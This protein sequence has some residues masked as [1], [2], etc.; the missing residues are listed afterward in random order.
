MAGLPSLMMESK[1]SL[2]SFTSFAFISS[3]YIGFSRCFMI[4][5]FLRFSMLKSWVKSTYIMGLSL[6][7]LS[8]ALRLRLAQCSKSLYFAK[9][10][11]SLAIFNFFHRTNKLKQLKTRVKTN[12]GDTNFGRAEKHTEMT[13]S[14]IKSSEMTA[15][16][17]KN[18]T[19]NQT[20]TKYV[21]ITLKI[22]IN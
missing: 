6:S 18:K 22:Q 20:F 3:V 19:S 21:L 1:D 12:W 17:K 10:L 9:L 16:W 11:L 8:P 15:K 4:S 2:I 13:K 7:R 14:S 5:I